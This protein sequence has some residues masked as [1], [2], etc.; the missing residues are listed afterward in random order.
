MTM[1][2]SG[3]RFDLICYP[4]TYIYLSNAKMS[5]GPHE[6]IFTIKLSTATDADSCKYRPYSAKCLMYPCLM[7]S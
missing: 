2:L 6:A 5:S 3:L 1:D 4:D 7:Q